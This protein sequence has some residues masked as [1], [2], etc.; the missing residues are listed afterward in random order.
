LAAYDAAGSD[1]ER[2]EHIITQKWI[3]SFGFGVDEYT[4]FRRTGYPFLYDGN[5]DNL[6]FTVR[7]REFPN[8]FPWPTNN[9]S[10]NGNAPPQKVVT[11]EE[12]KPFWM[13]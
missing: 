11:S 2:L 13:E 8:A 5:T 12:A 4:D 9:L 7:T 1:E 3:A 10:V 6:S